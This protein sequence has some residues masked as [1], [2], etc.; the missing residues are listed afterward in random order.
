M[1]GTS[2]YLGLDTHDVGTWAADMKIEAGM[3]FTCEPGIYIT[4]ESMGV[5]IEDDILVTENGNDN[6]MKNIPK[7]VEE[8]E[9]LMNS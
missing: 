5:R 9:E 1:H 2:H 7:E 6:L 4:D 8:I 3:V